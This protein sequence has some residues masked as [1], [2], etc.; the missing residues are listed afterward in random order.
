[1]KRE[2]WK[3]ERKKEPP[4]DRWFIWISKDQQRMWILPKE[5]DG[6]GIRTKLHLIFP[7][8]K[9]CKLKDRDFDWDGQL[10]TY[11]KFEPIIYNDSVLTIDSYHVSASIRTLST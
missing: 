2:W 10:E 9:F 7:R 3:P 11:Y 5:C 8:L 6:Y 1:M 4:K